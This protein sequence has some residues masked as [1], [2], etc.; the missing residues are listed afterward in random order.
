LI[1][2]SS[3]K[4]TQF[5][6]QSLKRKDNES[7]FVF[8]NPVTGK[9]YVDLKKAF[10][11]A[12]EEAGISGLR[13]HDLR[14]TF[15]SR[16]VE[17]GVDLITVKD[18]LGHSTVKVTE[19]YTHPNKSLKRKAVESLVQDPEKAGKTVEILAHEWHIKKKG[20]KEKAV[21]NSFSIN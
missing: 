11:T 15:A 9:P 7:E 16:L 20:K 19:R 21:T 3:K 18:L 14:H 8:S 1:I 17:N 6:G 12:C 10:K 13:F 5:F 4:F 2:I